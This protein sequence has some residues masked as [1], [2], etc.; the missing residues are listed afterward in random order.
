MAYMEFLVENN[1]SANMLANN[2]SALKANI[3]KCGLEFKLW[4]HPHIKY[5]LKALKIN[6]PLCPVCRNIMSLE[7]FKKLIKVCDSLDSHFTYKAIFLMAF[8]FPP[9]IKLDTSLICPV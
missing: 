1:V 9:Y 4:Y 2:V 7:M 5:F 3:V 6:R 8:W